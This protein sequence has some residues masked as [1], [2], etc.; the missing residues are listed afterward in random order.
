MSAIF[1]WLRR[2]RTLPMYWGGNSIFPPQKQKEQLAFDTECRRPAGLLLSI[3]A[4]AN[5]YDVSKNLLERLHQVEAKPEFKATVDRVAFVHDSSYQ[6]AQQLMMAHFASK[7]GPVFIT[8]VAG[9]TPL[10]LSDN[11]KA[12]ADCML[13]LDSFPMDYSGDSMVM[14]R[15][16]SRIGSSIK[17]G[18]DNYTTHFGVDFRAFNNEPNPEPNIPSELFGNLLD[19]FTKGK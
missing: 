11:I 18:M 13:I 2:D 16:K 9:A 8:P 10:N 4:A 6:R 12:H 15:K 19:R 17:A 14:V 5:R 1:D 7:R 3:E